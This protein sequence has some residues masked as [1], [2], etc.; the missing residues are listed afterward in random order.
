MQPFTIRRAT[1]LVGACVVAIGL[2]IAACSDQSPNPAAPTPPPAPVAT[3][4][5]LTITANG[6]FPSVAFVTRGLP[7]TIINNDTR[8][9][10]LHLDLEDQP[11][12]AGF[13]LAGEIP[14]GESRTT[15]NIAND[16]VDCDGHDHMSHGDKR[17]TVQLA[18]NIAG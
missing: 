11:G 4:Q 10:Q 18:V 6:V 8:P 16:A 1:R 17:F 2:A 15:G 3:Q 7:I 13:D 5:T 9:H 14:P 12:C